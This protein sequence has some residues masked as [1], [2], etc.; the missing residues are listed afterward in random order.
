MTSVLHILT[1]KDD[2][3]AAEIVAEQ[4]K[5]AGVR[6]EVFHLTEPTPDYSR[7]LERIFEADSVQV[8]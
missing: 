6:V 8:W 1:R 7:L 4:Q 2:P 3:L 5:Q